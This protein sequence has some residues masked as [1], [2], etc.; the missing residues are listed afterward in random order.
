MYIGI[1]IGGSAI[2]YGLVDET[3][4]VTNKNSIPTNRSKEAITQ[5]LVQMIQ[6]FKQ[7]VKN[8]QG[9]GISA[10]GVIKANGFMETAGAIE[11]LYEVNL[12]DL[13][14]EQVNLPV[15]VE[16]DANA[17]AIAEQWIGNAQDC[18]NYLCL[19]L[20]TGIGGGIVINGEVFR[21]HHGMA[22]EFGWM[23]I[24]H[25]PTSGNIE[26]SSLNYRGAVI[27]GLCRRYNRQ[28]LELDSSFQK[29]Y[30]AQE[31]FKLEESNPVAKKVIA[32]FYQELAIGLI[33]LISCFDPEKILIGG[34]ISANSE[35]FKRLTNEV[36]QLTQ[37]H[38]GLK[39][40]KQLASIE[41]AKLKNDA[42]LIGA[43]Y[44]LAK[45]I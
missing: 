34:A 20:G 10:P 23:L 14:E 40:M 25:L 13:I 2:K 3:G 16:N 17:A 8:I 39:H 43:V 29:T 22:G 19:V 42:G 12:K 27:G 18:Q 36:G 5:Q 33:N 41:P 37:N 15:Y 21:G 28:M 4:Q 30:N 45:H 6:F 44:Q 24:D 31:I 7:R 11:S 32:S 35:F 9:V 26:T 38:G 1:D